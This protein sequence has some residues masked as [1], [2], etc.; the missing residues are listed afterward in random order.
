M[1]NNIV[2]SCFFA[3]RVLSPF[4]CLKCTAVIFCS[5]KCR[6][7]AM[8]SYHK[9]ECSFH[10][11]LLTEG[12]SITCCLAVRLITQKG[13]KYFRDIRSKLKAIQ[14]V[15]DNACII[16]QYYHNKLFLG[17]FITKEV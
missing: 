11:S 10:G 15:R 4:P 5:S 2:Y 8:N 14:D 17:L 9:Y 16:K 6:E 7:I 12:A 3:F 1:L 13:L